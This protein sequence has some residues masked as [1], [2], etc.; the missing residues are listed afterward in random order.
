MTGGF[1]V[2]SLVSLVVTLAAFALLVL[3]RRRRAGF[4]TLVLLGLAVGIVIGILFRGHLTY[5]GFLGDLYVQVITAI[6]APLI[7]ISI[8]SSV[9]SL[10]STAKLR[11]IGLSSTF[12]LLLTN[13]IAIVLTLAIVLSIG[14]GTGVELDLTGEG[15]D[16]L[17]GLVRPLDQV[18]LGLVPANLAGDFVSNNIVPI[19]LFAILFAIAYL[20]ANRAPDAQLGAFKNVV[21]GA[22]RVVMTAVGFVIELTPYA[23]LALVAVTTATAVT[24]IEMVLSLLGILVLAVGIAFL[25]AYLVNGVLL[26]VF[27]DVNPI[28]WF[29]HMTAAQYTAFTTQSSVGTLPITIP[30]LTRKVGVPE[31]IATFA[32]PVGTT[33]GMPGC[34]GI[35]PIIVAVFSINVLGLDY[36]V[37]DYLALAGLC[38]LV[39][40]GTAGVPGTA[41]ITATAVLTA[42]GLPV[43][44]LVVLIPISAVAGTAST[45]ANVTAAATAATIVARRLGVLDDAMFRSSRDGDPAPTRRARRRSEPAAA[46]PAPGAEATQSAP[47]QDRAQTDAATA[48]LNRSAGEYTMPDGVPFGQCELPG[49]R[50]PETV[51]TS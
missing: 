29:R 16:S 31:D 40:L 33:I 3:L 28:R 46:T 13:A 10:G 6:V 19:I 1:D 4:T 18:L 27:A 12:W 7:F 37:W 38:M 8:L 50:L 25:D 45:M 20:V 14:L 32:A 22:K 51:R 2:L 34:A 5:V 9:T 23:V 26:R 47:S 30:S 39:S 43:E 42:V 24:R 35:W 11:T 41:I 17:E 21:D 44:I 49:S 36:S 48:V 15:A